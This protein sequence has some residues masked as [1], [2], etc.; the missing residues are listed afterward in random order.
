MKDSDSPV[1]NDEFCLAI[2][3]GGTKFAVAIIDRLGNI[4][5]RS[6]MDTPKVSDAE[7]LL[8]VLLALVSKVMSDAPGK[9]IRACGV[10][11]GGPMDSD[12]D[13]VSPLNIPGWRQFP[14]RTKLSEFLEVP[15]FVDNDAKAL[16]LGEG[17]IGTA[18]GISN[19]MSMVVSTGIGGGIVIDGSILHGRLGNAGHIGHVVVD[20]DGASCVC[21]GKGCLEAMASG[22]AIEAL[23]GKSAIGADPKVIELVG[24][25]VGRAVGS[26][27]NLLDLSLVTVAGSVALGYGLPFFLA[28]QREIERRCHLDFSTGTKIVPSILGD[29]APLIGAGA[30]GWQSLDVQELNVRI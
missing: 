13:R 30:L 5:G 15:I 19:Y 7:I 28:A 12:G 2:D 18:V 25:L 21:G 16:A 26:V 10:G 14:L 3:I 29:K 1:V 8:K 20:P 4:F 11:C 22:T 27:A 17:W 23:T 6:Q 9:P 24:T